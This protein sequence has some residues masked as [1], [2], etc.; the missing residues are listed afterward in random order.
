MANVLKKYGV[1]KGDR[2]TIYL[3]M[4]PE[5]TISMLACARIGAIHSVVFGGFSAN[6]L[7]DRIKDCTA[8]ILITTDIAIRNGKDI[9]YKVN[10]DDAMYYCPSVEKIIV[11]AGPYKDIKHT[12]MKSGRDTWWHDEKY[13]LSSL[14]LLGNVGEPINQKA[15][16]W[17]FEIVGASNSPIADTWWQTETGGIMLSHIPGAMPLKAGSANRPFPGV[18][19]SVITEE[20]I[21]AETEE[22]GC[23]VIEKPWPGMFMG[24]YGDNDNS[25]MK[26]IYFSKFDNKYFSGDSAKIDKEGLQ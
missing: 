5:L 2:V 23:L 17:Y 21:K 25:T 6:A 14:R 18:K 8:K 9:H 12:D 19:I 20:G 13:N 26:E 10:T 7:G 1:K 11:V 24:I 16:N 22:T 3:P 15:W 4:I